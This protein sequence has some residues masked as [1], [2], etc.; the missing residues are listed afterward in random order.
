MP[1]AAT[2]PDAEVLE[3]PAWETLPHERLSPSAE[4]VG[5]RLRTLRRLRAW[6]AGPAASAHRR[7]QRARRAAAARRRPRSAR[8]GR[9]HRRA[10]AATTSP[11]SPSQ[12]VDL[13]YTR[14]DMVTRRGEF[15]V[16][17]GILDVFPPDRRAPGARRLLRRRARA[18]AL[19]S[20]SPTSARS[21]SRSSE[22][23]AAAEPR[24]AAHRRRCGSARARCSTSSRASR[25]CSRRSPRASRSRAWSRSRRRS[26]TGWCRSPTTCRRMPRSPCS[27]PERVADR[28]RSASLETNREFLAAAWN[29]A[30]AGAEA[31]IDLDAGDFLTV[32]R[33]LRRRAADAQPVGGRCEPASDSGSRR[34][35]RLR[36]HRGRRRCRASPDRPRVRIEHVAEPAARRL[37]RRSSPRQGAGL[38][39]RAADVLAE[40]GLAARIVDELPPD[41]GGR[42][43]L[44]AAGIRR[45][46]LRDRRS[47]SSRCSARPSSTA[48]RS[49]TTPAR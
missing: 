10:A 33:E 49:A 46:G 47:S 45:G 30:T 28:A 27:R 38:V 4:T 16:R 37:D 19:R 29:A 44:P 41:A 12:L 26:S 48:A 14:V 7:R 11:S 36:P 17:G 35:R 1:S 9:A 18:A 8:A 6:R 23:R 21:P 13:A 42:R 25:R 2:L 24:A 32:A 40:A 43:R 31:P 39:E 3:F 34:R 15:A 20:R 22:R 5:K